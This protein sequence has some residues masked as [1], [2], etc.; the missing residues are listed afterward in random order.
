MNAQ[1]GG[2]REEV[3]LWR[4]GED[5]KGGVHTVH[6]GQVLSTL[7]PHLSV[8]NTWGCTQTSMSHYSASDFGR[9]LFP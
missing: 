5:P 8:L 7:G 1:E 2:I 6:L 9:R 4:G 3:V